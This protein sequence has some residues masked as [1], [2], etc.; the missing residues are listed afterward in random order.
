MNT[1]M[2]EYDIC[3][4]AVR[5]DAPVAHR[6]A[7]SIRRY[8]LPGSAALPDQTADY[9]RI[10]EDTEGE[11]FSEEKT[12][13]LDH[14]R[15][16]IIIC[17]PLT[18]ENKDILD[19]LTWFRERN[20]GE[21]IIAVIVRGEPA[22]AFP[23]GFIEQQVV[24]TILPDMTVRERIETIEPIAADLRA[25]QPWR[26]AQ[27]MRYETVRITASVLGIHPDV[28]EQRHRARIRRR[29]LAAAGTAAVI[30][31][32]AAGI[33]LRLGFI[34]REEGKIAAQQAE[35]NLQI[36]ERTTELLPVRFADDTEALRYV[37][38]AVDKAKNTMEELGKEEEASG[39]REKVRP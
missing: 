6:L 16:L 1:Q 19:R 15:F 12:R 33:F 17:S 22:D 3:I 20:R 11:P 30:F 10:C 31:L 28:L 5:E 14:S 35:L 9:R 18:K 2:E 4:I 23:E 37:N 29:I 32:T 34:A 24:R 26:L 8:R 13:I 25:D 27:L 21:H 7:C 38:I 39:S 36:A